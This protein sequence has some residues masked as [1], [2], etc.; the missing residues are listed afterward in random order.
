MDMIYFLLTVLGATA[1]AVDFICDRISG[2]GFVA[3]A[4]EGDVPTAFPAL[5]PGAVL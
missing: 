4:R 5:R 2:I 1:L 3:F